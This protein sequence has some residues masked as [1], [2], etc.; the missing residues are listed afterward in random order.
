MDDQG[1]MDL[2]SLSGHESADR[3]RWIAMQ[4]AIYRQFI[5]R[6]ETEGLTW[7]GDPPSQGFSAGICNELKEA[8]QILFLMLEQIRALE[9]APLPMMRNK[10]LSNWQRLTSRLQENQQLSVLGDLWQE[11]SHAVSGDPGALQALVSRYRTL[12]STFIGF[13]QCSGMKI[14]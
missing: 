1:Y 4:R 8:E 14:E 7:Q 11:Q 3:S 2:E 10:F 6:G 13:L 12:V 9:Q 5:D